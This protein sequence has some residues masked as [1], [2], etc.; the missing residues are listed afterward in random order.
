MKSGN[1]VRGSEKRILRFQLLRFQPLSPRPPAA[2]TLILVDAAR[3][4][5][6]L[7][8]ASPQGSASARRARRKQDAIARNATRRDFD[9]AG[10]ANFQP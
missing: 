5:G 7:A 9:P 10:R 3:T 8:D 1:K 4:L 6:I 2:L